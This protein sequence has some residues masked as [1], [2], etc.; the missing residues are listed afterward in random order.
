MIVYQITAAIFIVALL[1]GVTNPF[2]K[3][4]SDGI[5]KVNSNHVIV[6]TLLEI[7]FLFTNIKVNE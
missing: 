3:R 2:I 4:G 7:K 6:K 5:Q 1:W